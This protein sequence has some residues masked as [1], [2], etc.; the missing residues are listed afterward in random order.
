MY[1]E[2]INFG[3]HLLDTTDSILMPATLSLLR[4][5]DI[6]RERATM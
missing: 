1:V 3:W 6:P 2:P 5:G 4:Q